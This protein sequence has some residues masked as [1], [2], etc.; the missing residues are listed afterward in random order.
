MKEEGRGHT[1]EKGRRKEQG[2]RREER[3]GRGGGGNRKATTEDQEEAEDKEG[4]NLWGPQQSVWRSAEKW[5][6]LM[7][8]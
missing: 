3:M 6:W 1:E 7:G 4:P 2:E 5:F 8:P